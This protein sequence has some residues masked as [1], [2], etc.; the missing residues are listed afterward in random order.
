[1][2][3]GYPD[4]IGTGQGWEG[5]FQ[6]GQSILRSSYSGN[7]ADA[8]RL[9]EAAVNKQGMLW[10][11]VLGPEFRRK[12]GGF[13]LFLQAAAPE[14]QSSELGGCWALFFFF[15]EDFQAVTVLM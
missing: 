13:A 9:G 6:G 11:L 4:S 3:R 10:C 2:H 15:F 1:M 14:R 8:R 7:R 12:Q 5:A